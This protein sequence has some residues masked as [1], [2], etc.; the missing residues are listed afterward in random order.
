MK[1]ETLQEGAVQEA[2]VETSPAPKK[3]SRKPVGQ[4]KAADSGKMSTEGLDM[5]KKLERLGLPQVLTGGSL[6]TW[7]NDLESVSHVEVSR[8]GIAFTPVWVNDKSPSKVKPVVIPSVQLKALLFLVQSAVVRPV[9][10]RGFAYVQW[11]ATNAKVLTEVFGKAKVGDKNLPPLVIRIHN[12]SA[13]LPVLQFPADFAVAR[14]KEMLPILEQSAKIEPPQKRAPTAKAKKA[15]EGI[16]G[17]L[18]FNM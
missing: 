12:M 8:D 18:G 5:V 4:P 3:T 11:T 13:A 10:D 17:I 1:D 7:S 15:E 14:A 16:E 2:A 9:T 6:T